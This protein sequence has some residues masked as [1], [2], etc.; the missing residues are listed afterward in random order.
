MN[1]TELSRELGKLIQ[2]DERYIAYHHAKK[3]NDEDEALQ[4]MIGEFNLKRVSLNNEMSKLDK[5]QIKLSVLDAEIKHLYGEIMANENMAA[6]TEAKEEMDAMLAEINAIITMSANGEDPAT[7][8]PPT[9]GCSGG[10][11]TCGGCH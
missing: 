10:C 11:D 1:V 3:V 6:F 8:T 5:D 7:C 9:A 2:A 4:D